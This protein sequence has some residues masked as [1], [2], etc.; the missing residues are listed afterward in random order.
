M[1]GCIQEKVWICVH[2]RTSSLS[3]VQKNVTTKCTARNRLVYIVLIYV[4]CVCKLP[5]PAQEML[6]EWNW[7]LREKRNMQHR[8]QHKQP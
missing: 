1:L 7:C 2:L 6:D 4:L 5:S 8:K 3:F